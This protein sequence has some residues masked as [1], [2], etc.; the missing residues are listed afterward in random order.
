MNGIVREAGRSDNVNLGSPRPEELA[1]IVLTIRSPPGHSAIMKSQTGRLLFLS[2]AFSLLLCAQL[3]AE[4]M[5][6]TNGTSITRFDT[7]SL[8]TTTTVTLTG[9]QG[10][11]TIVGID[12]RASS[13]IAL[14]GVLYG[15]GSS[16]RLYIID[17]FTGVATQVGTAGLFSLS[18]TAFGTDFNPVPDRIRQVSNT[19]QNLRLNPDDATLSGNDPAL[20]PAGNVVAVAY[21]NN[22]FNPG[23]GT[24]LYAIDSVTGT[25]GIITVPNSGGPITTVG[26]LGLGT[27]LNEN[28]GFD[29]TATGAAFASITVGGQSRL[30]SINL[31]TGAAT[32]LGLIGT[33]TTSYLGLTGGTA[34]IPEP[35]T[36]ALLAAG[37][38]ALG[39][40][41]FRRTKK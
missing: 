29:I 1:K 12:L 20:N 2:G 33:G 23:T 3:R 40:R 38:L 8:G 30:Y 24:T 21:S 11:E 27:N 39:F 31:T 41:R 14:N 37:A 5:F 6:G 32:N 36:Y 25:L 16:N 35:S 4:L 34:P 22:D 13:N 18:G 19:E 26:S 10:G 7:L 17:P 28:I 9:L 15:V